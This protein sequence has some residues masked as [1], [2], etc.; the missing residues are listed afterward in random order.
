MS[1][2]FL[3]QMNHNQ[4]ETKRSYKMANF[5]PILESQH[6]SHF[7]QIFV[8]L[9]CCFICICI[10]SCFRTQTM[11]CFYTEHF[12]PGLRITRRLLGG[13]A[14]RIL[15]RNTNRSAHATGKL[16]RIRVDNVISVA[17]CSCHYRTTASRHICTAAMSFLQ[18]SEDLSFSR[19]SPDFPQCL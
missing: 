14:I 13:R 15:Q 5:Q 8:S 2:L 3:L 16:V 12:C 17:H 1:S 11:D 19:F 6:C 9:L 18:S 4:G 10:E 7:Q